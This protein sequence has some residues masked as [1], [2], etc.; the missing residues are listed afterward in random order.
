LRKMGIGL[1]MYTVRNES[2]KDFLGTL[3]EVAKL[4]YEGVE[5]AGYGGFEAAELKTHLQELNLKVIGS[6][7]SY[8]QLKENLAAEIAYLKQLGGQYIVC[9]YLL[10]EERKDWEAHFAFFA[11]VGRE[12]TANGLRFAYHNHDFEFVQKV[13]DQFV[14]DAMYSTIDSSILQV[15]MDIGWVQFIGQDPLA[16]I[17]Q[18]AGRLP[19]LHL[20]DFEHLPDGGIDT[21]EL[22]RG[23]I[24]LPDVIKAAFD[25]GVEWLI[26]EQ[27]HC[28]NPP[29]ESIAISKKWL[30]EHYAAS[31]AK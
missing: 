27:D 2:E 3:R 28:K 6:H 18:Y 8:K 21:K 23:K 17:A 19:L 31:I 16:Y 7:V 4:G 20:K 12:I 25:A 5:F 29:L 30:D 13:G 24:A 26:V 10:P 11:E 22:G 9:P 14:F 1:Q 15:E